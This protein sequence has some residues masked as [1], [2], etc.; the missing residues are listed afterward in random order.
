MR[1]RRV[2]P[3]VLAAGLGAAAILVGQGALASLREAPMTTSGGP[4]TRVVVVT[5]TESQGVQTQGFSDVPGPTATITVPPRT[6]SLLLARF[7]GEVRCAAGGGPGC[8]FRILI[9]GVEGNPASG[10]DNHLEDTSGRRWPFAI[11]RS[12]GPLGPGTYIVQVQAAVGMD[13]SPGSTVFLDDWS[14]TIERVRV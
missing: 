10:L 12:R 1:V 9:G 14:L 13:A 7:V 2:F 3:F 8:S 4:I 6:Q 11:E 5:D